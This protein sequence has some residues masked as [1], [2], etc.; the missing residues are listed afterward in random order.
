MND[1]ASPPLKLTP[2][3]ALHLA[4]GAKMVPFAGCAMPLQYPTGILKEH[5]HTRAS[6]GLFD[7]SHMGQ[8]FLAGTDPALALEHVTGADIVGLTEGGLRY[9]LLL[10][11][12]CG[13]E[14]DFIAGRIAGEDSLFLVV[15]ARRKEVN[16]QFIA[17]RASGAELC[18]A[19]ERALLAVQGP[20]SEAVLARHAVGAARLGFMRI[21]RMQ[22]AG[23]PALVSRSG[24]TGEDGFEISLDARD[25]EHVAR[26]LLAEPEV[27]P[28]GLGARDSLRL[29][30]GLALYGQDIDESTSPVAAGLAWTIGK[31][32]KM[33]RDFPGAD[34][35]MAELLDGPAMKRVGLALSDRTP[36]REGANIV[37]VGGCAAGRV[38]SGGFSPSLGRPIAMGYVQTKYAA[39]GTTLN[40]FVR[41]VARA[42]VVTPMPFVPH[43]YK[44]SRRG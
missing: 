35:I 26:V 5:L 8:A 15:N 12:A 24:Y 14:D 36:A 21:A 1:I 19:P 39:D 25:A 44:R 31:R 4:L 27:L 2:L 23:V 17:E 40:I 9:A 29:E 38:T 11:D 20:A 13:I 42:A 3:H 37:E 28:V 34:R 32:R 16:F 43:R 18:P 30:A 7:V 10:N 22:V 6:V 41:E 33:A